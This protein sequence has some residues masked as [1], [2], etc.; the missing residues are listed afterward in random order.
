MKAFGRMYLWIGT[1]TSTA[2]LAFA[3]DCRRKVLPLPA[4]SDWYT[5]VLHVRMPSTSPVTICTISVGSGCTFARRNLWNC[6]T[7]YCDRVPPMSSTSGARLRS[8]FSPF[9]GEALACLPS[10]AAPSPAAPAAAPLLLPAPFATPLAP[11]APFASPLPAGAPALASPAPAGPSSMAKASGTSSSSPSSA[12]DC[13]ASGAAPCLRSACASWASASPVA[14]N[15]T[16]SICSASSRCC[17][18]VRFSAALI[19]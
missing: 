17:S 3:S 1:W 18:K 5:R 9:E 7:R 13:Q 2:P 19:T 6:S 14:W 15:S 4:P 12:E 16:S 11:L 8:T 10:R